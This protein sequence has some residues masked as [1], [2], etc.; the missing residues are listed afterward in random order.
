MRLRV[1]TRWSRRSIAAN[2]SM[3]RPFDKTVIAL[4]R[5]IASSVTPGALSLQQ[6]GACVIHGLGTANGY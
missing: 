4:R 2:Y 5:W 1:R 3:P 6:E